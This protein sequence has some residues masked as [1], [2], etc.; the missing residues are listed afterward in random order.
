MG[1]AHDAWND[2]ALIIVYTLGTGSMGR[3]RW[4]YGVISREINP[5]Y[6]TGPPCQRR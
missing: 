1:Y 2:V 3:K 4:T 6:S 5:K